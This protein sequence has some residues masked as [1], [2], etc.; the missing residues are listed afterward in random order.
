MPTPDPM[1]I[2]QLTSFVLVK[3]LPFRVAVRGESY[4]LLSEVDKVSKQCRFFAR[5]EKGRPDGQFYSFLFWHAG[6]EVDLKTQLYQTGMTFAEK[7]MGFV[8]LLQA[9][10]DGNAKILPAPQHS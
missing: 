3:E 8:V 10:H 1:A 2:R 9:V 4:L 7:D 6:S 5:N